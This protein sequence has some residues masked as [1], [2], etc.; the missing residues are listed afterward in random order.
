MTCLKQT[1]YGKLGSQGCNQGAYYQQISLNGMLPRYC[2]K[3]QILS[4]LLV[5]VLSIMFETENSK[6]TVETIAIVYVGCALQKDTQ[7]RREVSAGKSSLHHAHWA[8]PPEVRPHLPREVPFSYCTKVLYGGGLALAH[9][10]SQDRL[11]KALSKQW[12]RRQ[13]SRG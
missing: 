4:K 5:T 12:K 9:W 2:G 10:P 1:G 11:F 8:M 7:R 6:W 3:L 13:V